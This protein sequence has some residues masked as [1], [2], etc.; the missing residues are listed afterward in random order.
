MSTIRFSA[1]GYSPSTTGSFAVSL[2]GTPNVGDQIV[3]FLGV[4]N[5]IVTHQPGYN[6]TL[7]WFK[8]TGIRGRNTSTLST[9][10]HTWNAS[11]SGSSVNFS[12][13][14]AP[15]LGIGDKSLASANILW[16]ALVVAGPTGASE[17]TVAGSYDLGFTLPLGPLKAAHSEALVASYST[18]PGSL[19]LSDPNAVL[20]QSTNGNG[21]FL[22]VWATPNPSQG[23]RATVSTLNQCEIL[24]SVLTLND[25]PAFLYNPAVLQEGPVAEDPLLYRYTLTRYYTLLNNSGA[26]SQVRY[27]STD[28]LS[29]ATQV[30]TNNSPVTSTDRTNILNAGVGGEFVSS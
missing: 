19:T 3:V 28:Q 18:S 7:Q 15:S 2:G 14:P 25:N 26:F 4:D 21:A 13:S 12:V 30:F 5:E 1:S 24:S 23:Y 10:Q 17:S 11:D 20:Q 6:T 9:Y 22:S 27:S 29:A 16:V 8:V